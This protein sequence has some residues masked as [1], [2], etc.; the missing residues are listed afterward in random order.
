MAILGSAN[1]STSLGIRYWGSLGGKMSQ[2]GA[3]VLT[4]CYNWLFPTLK[5]HQI[6][7]RIFDN[8]FSIADTYSE[9]RQSREKQLKIKHQEKLWKLSKTWQHAC[10]PKAK[11]NV[12]AEYII[13]SV[14]GNIK[15]YVANT[16]RHCSFRLHPIFSYEILC[17]TILSDLPLIYPSLWVSLINI[18]SSKIIEH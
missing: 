3:F 14:N 17:E 2:I 16:L 15:N 1:F 10:A 12:S 8:Q 9:S 13:S 5:Y 7:L 6:I 11:I 4:F 18:I